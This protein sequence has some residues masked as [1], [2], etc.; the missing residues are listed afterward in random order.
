MDSFFFFAFQD[1]LVTREHMYCTVGDIQE[2]VYAFFVMLN[3]R[4]EII[5]FLSVA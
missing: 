4:I 5:Y 1:A 3:R 2:I